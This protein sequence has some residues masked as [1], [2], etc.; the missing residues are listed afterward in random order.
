M[1][2]ISFIRA[3]VEDDRVRDVRL[4]ATLGRRAARARD[5]VDAVL[6]GEGEHR[7]DLL[8]A[9]DHRHR[10]GRRQRVDPEDVLQLAEVVDAA[11]LQDLLVGDDVLGAEDLPK[12]LD[13]RFSA[14]LHG[15]VP[16][17]GGVVGL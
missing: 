11:L 12:T 7:G 9:A 3:A 6:V 13:D 2:R 8:G 1:L 16:L 4:E 5:D 17:R 10:G 15:G 14:Q